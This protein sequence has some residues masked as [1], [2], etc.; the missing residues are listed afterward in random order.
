VATV[1]V[2]I[3]KVRGDLKLAEKARSQTY[4]RVEAVR[5]EVTS[6][7]GA[8]LKDAV[9]RIERA[10]DVLNARVEA[11]FEGFGHELKELHR[12]VS[13]LQDAALRSRPKR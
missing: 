5:H 1:L 3:V 10:M 11:R 8:S 7:S 13:V 9:A 12:Q 6:N 4:Q 2:Q